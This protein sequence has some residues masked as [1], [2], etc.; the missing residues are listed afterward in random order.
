[1]P[2]ETAI[3][4]ILSGLAILVSAVTARLNFG[5][6][7]HWADS[8]KRV[9]MNPKADRL[10]NPVTTAIAAVGACIAVIGVFGLVAA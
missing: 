8:T 7:S 3:V 1:M 2:S 5:F 9:V 10:V 4:M 6:I